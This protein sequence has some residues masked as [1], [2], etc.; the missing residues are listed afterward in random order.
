MSA[1]PYPYAIINRATGRIVQTIKLIRQEA[2]AMYEDADTAARALPEGVD[3]TTHTYDLANEVYVPRAPRVDTL[4]MIK[5]RV[6][7]EMWRKVSAARLEVATNLPFQN[8]AYKLKREEAV[9]FL[10]ISPTPTDLTPY[11]LL[12]SI[13]VDRGMTP[14]AL[15]QLWLDNNDDWIPFLKATETLRDGAKFKVNAATTKAEIDAALATFNTT[16]NTL[17]GG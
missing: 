8:E 1:M 2:A 9:A 3:N 12:A 17:Q 7:D 5:A 4:D 6:I 13:S 16:L 11:P 10:G 14:S 15:A